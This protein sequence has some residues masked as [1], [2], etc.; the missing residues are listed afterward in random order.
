MSTVTSRTCQLYWYWFSVLMFGDLVDIEPTTAHADGT[1]PLCEHLSTLLGSDLGL[2]DGTVL[3]VDGFEFAELLPDVDGEACSDSSAQSS[4][5]AH[6]RTVDG[7]SDD[8]CLGLQFLF[9]ISFI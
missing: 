9:R 5:F 3:L 7:D 2:E 8:V 6:G 4:C 1:L